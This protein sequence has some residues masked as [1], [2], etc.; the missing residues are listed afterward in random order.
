M[1]RVFGSA[2]TAVLALLLVG[3]VIVASALSPFFL[4]ATTLTFV[5]QYI[6]VLGILGLAQMAVMIGGGPGID[7]SLGG[8]MSLT[9]LAVA[10]LLAAGVPVLAASLIGLALG[11]LLGAING[12]IIAV[13]G[14]DAL[15]AT[16][17]TMLTFGGL[18]VAL[19]SGAPIGGM[20]DTFAAL[21][22]GTTWLVPNHVLFVFVPVA[23]AAHL[24]MRHSRFG[25]HVTAAGSAEGAAYLAGISIIRVRFW[26]YV[27]SGSMAAVAGI[28]QLAWFQT[29]RPDAG[30]GMELLSVTVAVLGGTHILGGTGSVLGVVLAVLVVT[31]LQA[32]LQLANISQAWQ[33]GTVGL[34][35][36]ASA[37]ADRAFMKRLSAGLP[38][39]ANRPPARDAPAPPPPS[40]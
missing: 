33:L 12:V 35:L 9:G 37:V 5:L 24:V 3:V 4:E 25:A 14:V 36:I 7:L 26:L 30:M 40:R 23:I 31:T 19:T 16:L 6:P 18:A 22:Q 27:A 2:R 34:L 21:A 39:T 32:G 15:M 1:V 11:A 13:L 38:I 17:A 29:A 8:I 28:M 10:A 20:P